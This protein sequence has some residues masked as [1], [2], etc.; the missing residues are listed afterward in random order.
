MIMDML[1]AL[2]RFLGMIGRILGRTYRNDPTAFIVGVGML[3]VAQITFKGIL[4]WIWLGYMGALVGA[5]YQGERI[6]LEKALKVAISR[7]KKEKPVQASGASPVADAAVTEP[8]PVT[9]SPVTM[10][11]ATPEKPKDETPKEDVK[12]VKPKDETP[13]MPDVVS[14]IDKAVKKGVT[15]TGAFL[16]PEEQTA[17]NALDIQ[18]IEASIKG[19]IKGQD[20]AIEAVINTLKRSAAGIR[21]KA[22]SPLC[23][24]LFVGCTG[25]G[26]TEIVKQIAAVTDRHLVR[27]DMPNYSSEAG[28]W[29]L[30]GSPPGYVGSEKSG[31]LTGEIRNNPNAILLLDE[32]EKAHK[33]MWDPFLRVLDEGKLKDQ[34]HGF[35]ANFKNVMIFLT[36]NLLQHEDFIGDE[37]DLRNKILNEGYFRPELLNR[38]DRI[39]MFKQFSKQIMGEIVQNMLAS[40]SH[41]FLESNKIDAEVSIDRA[42]IENVIS[43]IDLK[44]GVRDA[45]RY[46]DKHCGDALA[47][48]FL[49]ARTGNI[50][51]CRIALQVNSGGNMEV[52]IG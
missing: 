44:F 21:I 50:N 37:K 25:T 19:K 29:E 26:K 16:S 5:M 40:F 49:R 9:D 13:K 33:K 14:K 43:N 28:I 11:A 27:F 8:E 12:P 24:F 32:I 51:I 1:H 23:V 3:I 47:E 2:N 17:S 35:T 36:S 48:A 42:V 30:I 46:I 45:E 4:N 6:N 39:V 41:K 38:I 7:V 15:F 20:H 18:A 52:T 34:S 10:P 31:R 22:E